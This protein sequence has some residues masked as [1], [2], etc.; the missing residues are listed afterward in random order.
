MD[1][2]MGYPVKGES[3]FTLLKFAVLPIAKVLVMCA[4]GLLLASRTVNILPANSRKQLSKLVFSLFLPC[5]IFTQLGK[6]VTV[7]KI[8]EWWF[9]PVNVVLAAV[10]GCLVGYAV[11]HLIKPPPE[12]FNF[13]VVFIGIG[14][15]GNIPLVII[16]AICRE[17]GN[18]FEDP[19]T[20]NT[21]GVAYIS[22]GQ[23]VGAVI[24]YTYVYSMLAPPA[25]SKEL[26][27]P[28]PTN[29]V[30]V[31]EAA[32][33]NGTE[34][35]YTAHSNSEE[36]ALLVVEAPHETPQGTLALVKAWLSQGRIRDIMQPAVVASLLALLFG[37]VPL[38]RSLI[39]TEHSFFYFLF[40]SLNILGGATVPC[41]MLVLGGN[42][43]GGPGASKLG[44]RTTVAI[45]ATRLL[46]IPLIGVATVLTAEKLGFLP[47]GN[48]TFKFVLLLQHT[49]PSSILA[50]AVTNL[51]GHAEKEASAIL[52]YEHVL[53]ILSMA[54][55]L[56]LY[57]NVLF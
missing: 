6:A 55:W 44:A 16:G 37:C 34:V 51:R 47:E 35:T 38:L 17:K 43:L 36:T 12:F 29:L 1:P 30:V 14:N 2:W 31:P 13:T 54:G 11:A 24:V 53:A 21:N 33:A 7:E 46:L 27:A 26:D 25:R 40:D 8:I 20:C 41:I 3:V 4:L 50:G 48:R 9:I 52:F 57:I 32:T 42:L 19:E 18:P 28:T 22:F 56:V 39:F 5:L 45:V 10:F 15:I 49:M 23:W